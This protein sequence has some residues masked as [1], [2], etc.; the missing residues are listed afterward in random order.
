MTKLMLLLIEV[1]P[2]QWRLMFLEV[3]TASGVKLDP[4][5]KYIC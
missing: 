3:Y 1:T 4:E 2:V 5:Q